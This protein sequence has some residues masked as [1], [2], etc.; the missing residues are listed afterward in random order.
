[1]VG[2]YINRDGDHAKRCGNKNELLH[3]GDSR[4]VHDLET[5]TQQIGFDVS[6]LAPVEISDGR[7]VEITWVSKHKQ[8]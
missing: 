6:Q 3:F 1:M 8:E 4:D 2:S 5:G 7:G